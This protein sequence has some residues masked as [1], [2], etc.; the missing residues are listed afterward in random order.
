M[1]KVTKATGAYAALVSVISGTIVWYVP[2]RAGE[3]EEEEVVNFH[4]K[5][6]TAGGCMSKTV[7]VFVWDLT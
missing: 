3:E 6:V 2:F 4:P 7:T 5:T 1:I